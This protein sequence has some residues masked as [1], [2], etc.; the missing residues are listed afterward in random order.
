MT[1]MEIG[2]KLVALVR[3][4]KNAEA[5]QQLYSPDIVSVEAGAPPGGDRE[6]HGLPACLAKGKAWGE[7]NEVHSGEVEGP[8]PHD[9]RFAVVYRYDITQKA[10]GRRIKMNEVALFTVKADKIVREEFFYTMG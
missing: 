6:T 10:S 3:E 8:F 5:M 2:T 4:H 7:S 1:S 9:D